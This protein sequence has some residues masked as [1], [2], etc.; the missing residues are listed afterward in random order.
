[1]NSIREDRCLQPKTVGRILSLLLP[2]QPNRNESLL[3]AA[4][5]TLQ[6]R[7]G[8]QATIAFQPL[9]AV[10]TAK[11]WSLGS[12][13][14]KSAVLSAELL[15]SLLLEEFHLWFW[16]DHAERA[17]PKC[18]CFSGICKPKRWSIEFE[19]GEFLSCLLLSVLTC[20]QY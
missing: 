11:R 5:W 7:E 16:P 12:M 2:V 13:L 20:R 6:R 15:P 17:M 18:S 9:P 3:G 14:K 1:M 4:S 10:V 19:K 8:N